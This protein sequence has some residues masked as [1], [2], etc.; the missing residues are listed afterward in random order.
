MTILQMSLSG[1]VLIAVI[2]L[3]RRVLLYRLPKW[4]FL[5]LWGVAL[6]R[7]LLPF[8][9]PSPVSVYT[10]AA[11]FV[12]TLQQ[13]E[14]PASPPAEAPDPAVTVPVPGPVT[15]PGT[16]RE[17][18]Q[19]PA[20]TV[21]AGPAEAAAPASLPPFTAVHRTGA[22]LCALFFAAAYLWNLY[23][24]RG[25]VPAE[26]AFV[27]RWRQAR[28]ALIPIRIRTSAAISA[29]LSYG[30]LRPTVLLPAGTDWQDEEQLT[31]I[32]TH[33]YIHIRRGDLF[34][35]LLLAGALCLHWFDP[36]VWAMYFCASR[37]LELA[38]DEAVVRA[39][40]L[41][42]RKNYACALLQAAA[43]P[44][45][46]LCTA[47]K[48]KHAMEE[49]ITAIMKTKKQTAAALTAALLLVAGVTAVFAT[50]QA[51]SPVPGARP[52]IDY[53]EDQIP[54]G[55]RQT[56]ELEEFPGT[57]FTWTPD[58]V[59]AREGE[60][61]TE[62]FWGMPVQNVFLTD[63][64]GDGLPELCATIHYG[65]GLIDQHVVAY[66]HAAKARYT[67]WDRGH[68]DYV[69]S[70][71]EGEL[72]VTETSWR[73]GG[74]STGR[75]ALGTYNRLALTDVQVVVPPV[76]TEPLPA[77]EPHERD[78]GAYTG[79]GISTGVVLYRDKA[80]LLDLEGTPAV[81]E[82]MKTMPH[83]IISPVYSDSR[84][85]I[86]GYVEM[87]SF[88]GYSGADLEEELEMVAEQMRDLGATQAEI[89]WDRD[90]RQEME[91]Q[92]E[93]LDQLR[94]Q[95][96]DERDERFQEV[97]RRQLDEYFDARQPGA[98]KAPI[99]KPVQPLAPGDQL[100]EVPE[101]AHFVET[102]RWGI[103][104]PIPANTVIRAGDR[105]DLG[106]L[107]KY[108]YYERELEDED[109]RWHSFADGSYGATLMPS[110][111]QPV[112]VPAETDTGR[113]HPV[114]GLP[115]LEN[116]WG[117]PDGD[118]PQMTE[119]TVDSLE[120]AA[121][122]GKYLEEARGLYPGDYTIGLVNKAA[123]VQVHYRE[124]EIR[125]RLPDGVYP[126]NSKGETYGCSP[127]A[128]IVGYEPDLI[129]VC[130]TNGAYGYALKTDLED[131]G[132]PGGIHS[133]A[134][135]LAYME[136]RKDQPPRIIPVYDVEHETVVGHFQ[137]G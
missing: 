57:V 107:L 123:I 128:D 85:D 70:L 109:I 81:E 25:A 56:L 50:V 14:I 39:L 59:T 23:R 34:W 121:E 44:A 28:P 21:P 35:K 103:P 43:E 78:S 77:G 94:Q 69:L 135:A 29:P 125:T 62:L 112:S 16:F 106:E 72:L 49:R 119:F 126:V 51:E 76:R 101:Y 37:D 36:L 32:L 80:Y 73:T 20:A 96:I 11:Q 87:Y 41:G 113:V 98:E 55:T 22:V 65:Y 48:G 17:D 40:G 30:L 54:W 129:A 42:I 83:L 86:V 88:W 134:D 114:T 12:Q 19:A 45:S 27:R 100:P 91:R 53:A 104:D 90:W 4:T 108:L 131:S 47:Y 31:Y 71:E 89:D 1:A 137:I 118:I 7:L 127:D 111:E 18:G 68:H 136:W 3:L 58:R 13:E 63:L 33:E 2:L 110:Q 5:L 130:A 122:L 38:C 132:Y 117:V 10:G 64:T 133:P 102:D 75:L 67:L 95:G 8:T 9:V 93:E 74:V 84:E 26:G 115:A 60:E 82:W 61:E 116:R 15:S 66:D 99:V 6:C 97:G 52:W 105:R 92:K 24:F 124:K 120:D 46:P 79:D